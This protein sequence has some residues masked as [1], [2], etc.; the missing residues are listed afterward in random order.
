MNT[1][2]KIDLNPDAKPYWSPYLAGVGLGL[3]LLASF[4]ILGKGLGAS[5]GF[6]RLGL[7]FMNLIAPEHVRG[8][9]HASGLFATDYHFMKDGLVFLAIGVAVGGFFSALSGRR[10]VAFGTVERGPTTTKFRRLALAL[11]GGL[12]MGFAARLARGCTSGQALS[13]GA[14]LALGSW[15]FMIAVFAGGFGFAWFVRRQWK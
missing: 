8:L 2:S 4:L 1:V 6:G 14:L 9:E 13:G 11:I 15:A 5:G 3:V 7:Y 12:L 10:V